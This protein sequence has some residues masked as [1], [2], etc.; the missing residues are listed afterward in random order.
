MELPRCPRAAGV[1]F[2][3][4][5]Q[6][7]N[8]FGFLW[9]GYIENL[10]QASCYLQNKVEMTPFYKALPHHLFIITIYSPR[11]TFPLFKEARK[12]LLHSV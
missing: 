12:D 8:Y 3:V 6:R 7:L 10:Q 4:H 11:P 1:H 5:V 2:G 9:L